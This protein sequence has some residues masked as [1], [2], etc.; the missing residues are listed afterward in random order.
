[1]PKLITV[2]NIAPTGELRLTPATPDQPY[3]ARVEIGFVDLGVV[4]KQP[5]RRSTTCSISTRLKRW[6]T[7]PTGPAHLLIPAEKKD[8]L[9]AD[10][11]ICPRSGACYGRVTKSSAAIPSTA[12]PIVTA[13][14]SR[15]C[16]LRI[17]Y[18]RSHQP[19]QN[20]LIPS[21]RARSPG[22]IPPYPRPKTKPA[23]TRPSSPRPARAKCADPPRPHRRHP[24]EHARIRR[25]R[26]PTRVMEFV[27]L[28]PGIATGAAHSGVD[29][30]AKKTQ[31]ED[32]RA[33]G[34]STSMYVTKAQRNAEND[35]CGVWNQTLHHHHIPHR[36][37]SG[38]RLSL[39]LTC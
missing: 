1:M 31:R 33:R 19:G 29:V 2:K 35:I 3:F 25:L 18:E 34:V 6:A 22:L 4:A 26:P 32:G 5:K 37:E 23:T 27:A 24:G 30:L 10:S 28:G 13:S 11:P 7:D 21:P 39:L 9:R 14:P 12:S 20:L 17:I 36:T 8:A 16:E 15:H 38:I